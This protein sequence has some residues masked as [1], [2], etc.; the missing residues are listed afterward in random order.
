MFL[1]L[2]TPAFRMTFFSILIFVVAFFFLV[3]FLTKINLECGLEETEDKNSKGLTSALLSTLIVFLS[4]VILRQ[5][6]SPEVFA[7]HI[8]FTV[9]ILYFVFDATER[10][11][12]IACFLTGLSIA[13]QHLTF[14]LIPALLWAY[15]EFWREYKQLAL[16]LT[17]AVVGLSVYLLLPLRAAL[18]P[19]ANWGNPDN[20]SRFMSDLERLQYGGDFPPGKI[21]NALYD[22]WL[23][24]KIFTLSGW[25]VLAVLAGLGWWS[26]RR[27]WPIAYWIGLLVS[28]FLPPLLLRTPFTPESNS[29][30]TP[31]MGPFFI[32]CG[33]GLLKGMEWLRDKLRVKA[34]FWI[35][36]GGLTLACFIL[37][38]YSRLDQSRNFS[39]EE[40]GRDNLMILPANSVLYSQGDG[41]TF[42]LEY[43]KLLRGLRADVNLFDLMGGVLKTFPM[44]TYNMPVAFQEEKWEKDNHPSEIFYSEK[45]TEGSRQLALAGLLFEVFNTNDPWRDKR[46]WQYAQP[47]EIEAGQDYLSRET[48]AR[49]YLFRLSRDPDP[50]SAFLDAEKVKTLAFDNA[51]LLVNLGVWEK[52]HGQLESAEN[53]LKQAL[54][55]DP[56]NA[57][58][59]FDLGDIQTA[60]GNQKEALE[61]NQRAA[62]FDPDNY[63][64][65]SHLAYLLYQ[66]NHLEEAK[67][68]WGE[69]IHLNPSFPDPYR[70]L[71][72]CN[73]Q[74]NPLFARQMFLHYLSLVPDPPDKAVI[75]EFLR[76]MDKLYPDSHS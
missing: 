26:A 20:I 49:F 60:E 48:G 59:W 66:S 17:F 41:I 37:W 18:N 73:M 67:N 29:T 24:L 64:Y 34:L 53:I 71:G 27:Q 54:R 9:L 52:D 69:A 56:E 3:S 57:L 7:L 12:P 6:L 75:L 62:Q 38:P 21:L 8:L 45:P 16:G 46:F 33:P 4:P 55:N 39:V 25:G 76:K 47:P 31:F 2:G 74:N 65:H 36:A 51:R 15:R 13:H 32:W 63:K 72:F 30:I 68:H 43:L 14:L 35:L 10:T 70:N 19:L 22:F 50:E 28:F 5:S 61:D 1:P 42:P 44:D 40:T 11:W 58:G 23:Y